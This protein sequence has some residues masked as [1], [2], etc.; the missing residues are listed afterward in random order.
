MAAAPFVEDVEGPGAGPG[1]A[2]VE[3]IVPDHLDAGGMEMGS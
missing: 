2:G 1:G 3:E